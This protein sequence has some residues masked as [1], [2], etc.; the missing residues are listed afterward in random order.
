MRTMKSLTTTGVPPIAGVRV[1]VAACGFAELIAVALVVL[2][3]CGFAGSLAAQMTEPPPQGFEGATVVERPDAQVPLGV[4]FNDE[5]GRPVRLGDFF[6]SGRPVLLTMIYC[7]CPSL[8][9][10]TLNGVVEAI[11]PLSLVPGR[12][13]EIVTVD[14]DPSEDAALAAAKKAS[15]IKSLGKPEAAAGWHFLTSSRP[16]AARAV[17]D[18]IG[19]GYK[20]DPKGEQY[21]HQTAIYLCT[22]EGRVSR[23]LLGVTYDSEVLRV[24][25]AQASEGKIGLGL[26][27]VALSCGLVHFDAATGKY[28]WAAV[29]LMRITGIATVLA[30]GCVIG[31]LLYRESRKKPAGPAGPEA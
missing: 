1:M 5:E 13:F 7:K 25:L 8:C 30:L 22:P 26:L 23:T 6:H 9:N 10:L 3:A 11:R 17:G 16:E 21:L 31:T 20:L 19:F 4:E 2:A 27:G 15:Y 12:Q 29:A 24:G 28:V 18:A 14:F